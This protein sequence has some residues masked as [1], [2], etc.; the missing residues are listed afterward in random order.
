MGWFDDITH[1]IRNFVSQVAT[2]TWQAAGQGIDSITHGVVDL[3]QG[4]GFNAVGEKLGKR[5]NQGLGAYGTLAGG[6]FLQT[7]VVQQAGRDKT[8]QNLTLGLSGDL[9][10]TG[11]LF[12]T[13]RESG[14]IN[15]DDLNSALRFGGKAIAIG[16]VAGL[17]N[18]G[19]LSTDTLGS[20]S[21]SSSAGFGSSAAGYGAIGAGTIA[22][23]LVV[24]NNVGK[25]GADNAIQDYLSDVTGG[26]IPRSPGSSPAPATRGPQGSAAPTVS[27]PWQFADSGIAGVSNQTLLLGAAA[28]LATVLVVRMVKK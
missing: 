10:G 7:D 24:A 15:Q 1:P 18:P 22:T 28:V 23:G 3:A 2:N 17:Y 8:T 13:A 26:L 25:K 4:G 21:G 27:S 11:N 12:R 9:A 14:N 16:S 6:N 20:L 5:L 19:G